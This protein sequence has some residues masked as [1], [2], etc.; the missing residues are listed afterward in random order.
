MKK[1]GW[2]IIVLVILVILAFVVFRDGDEDGTTQDDGQ[3][4]DEETT[5]VEEYSDIQTSDDVFDEIDNSLDYV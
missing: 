1:L 3:V 2:I 5:P 4:G